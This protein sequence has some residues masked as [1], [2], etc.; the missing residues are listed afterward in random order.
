LPSTVVLSDVAFEAKH[1]G[2]RDALGDDA[3]TRS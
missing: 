3:F 1:K 2:I